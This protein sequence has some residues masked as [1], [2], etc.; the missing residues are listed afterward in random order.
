MRSHAENE[1]RDAE[2]RS[3]DRQVQKLQQNIA[4]IQAM[5]EE[6][7]TAPA[8]AHATGTYRAQQKQR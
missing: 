6:E 8:Q 5:I 4:L 7:T 2:V 1:H 3:C